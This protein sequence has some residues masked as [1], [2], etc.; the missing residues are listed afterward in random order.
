MRANSL[1]ASLRQETKR[2]PIDSVIPVTTEGVYLEDYSSSNQRIVE[3]MDQIES[4]D[5]PPLELTQSGSVYFLETGGMGKD[6]TFRYLAYRLLRVSFVPYTL[7]PVEQAA[8][9]VKT[10]IT[11]RLNNRMLWARPRV[12]WREY[13]P[14]DDPREEYEDEL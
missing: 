6:N 9:R 13:P 3:I 10:Q 1:I 11:R 8:P 12:L 4:G 2:V 7:I 14:E 5:W